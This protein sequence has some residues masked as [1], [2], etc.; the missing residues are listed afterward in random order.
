MRTHRPPPFRLLGCQ[1]NLS[2]AI[3][4][5]T[6]AIFHPDDRHYYEAVAG[7]HCAVAVAARRFA[8]QPAGAIEVP[9]A[10][11][12]DAAR[13]ADA[14]AVEAPLAAEVPVSVALADEAHLAGV[15]AAEAEDCCSAGALAR[16][17]APVPA[18]ESVVAAH[19]HSR[20]GSERVVHSRLPV[21]SALAVHCWPADVG[22][23]SAPR[24]VVGPRCARVHDY[25]PVDGHC[26]S[27]VEWAPGGHCFPAWPS[28]SQGVRCCCSGGLP[29]RSHPWVAGCRL[30]PRSLV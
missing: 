7:A 23:C 19:S 14:A 1:L 4:L 26:C 2:P 21:D 28:C 15:A 25:S 12:A 18:A 17:E 6:A 10:E 30:R 27:G 5:P 22:D 16:C 3:C 8:F 13:P 9:L 24:L 20:E 29:S 11:A